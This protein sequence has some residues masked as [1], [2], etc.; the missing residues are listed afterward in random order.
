[1]NM[2][3]DPSKVLNEARDAARNKDYPSALERYRWF[4]DNALLHDESY[5]G[6][7]LSFCLTEWA[8]LGQEFPPASEAL[9]SLKE[10][11]LS[12]FRASNSR[13][14]FRELASIC[15]VLSCSEEAYQ[16][17]RNVSDKELSASLFRSIY[18]YCA[19]NA[20]WDICREYLGNGSSQYKEALELLDDML[21]FSNEQVEDEARESLLDSGVLGFKRDV[22]W[23][24]A[25]LRHAHAFDEYDAAMT[26]LKSD[27]RQR[28]LEAVFLEIKGSA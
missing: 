20:I 8:R 14:S 18:E 5:Y 3:T 4:Y 19:S 23:L 2:E 16:E 17:F 13:Q 22:A 21:K 9:I 25:M 15:Q 10:K 26:V 11:T 24:L 7:R 12:V 27:L 6:V 1:M 28:K